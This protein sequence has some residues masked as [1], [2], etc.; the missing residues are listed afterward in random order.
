[1]NAKI[2]IAFMLA[3]VLLTTVSY[4]VEGSGGFSTTRLNQ[5]LGE[6]GTVAY[7]DSTSGFPTAGYVKIGAEEIYYNGITATAFLNLD[8]EENET[9]AS[10]Y[11]IRSKVYSDGA[12][13]LNDAMGMEFVEQATDSGWLGMFLIPKVF[14]VDVVPDLVMWDFSILKSSA[15][16]QMFRTVLFCFSV[17]FIMY[18]V[19][20]SVVTI[21]SIG[22]SLLSRFGI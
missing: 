18:I 13:N 12:S 8:R 11:V 10:Y 20:L 3:F 2:I 7:V 9:D 22:G 19:Y 17:G 16:M 21:G 15:P 5:P 1:M 6:T 14:L 4:L